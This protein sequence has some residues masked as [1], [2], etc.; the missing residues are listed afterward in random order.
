MEVINWGILGASGFARKQTAPAIHMARN[1]RLYG[2]ASRSGSADG[3]A[4]YQP[5][6]KVY[7]GYEAMLDDPDIHAVYIPLRIHLQVVWTIRALEAG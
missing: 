4:D 6:L 1:T 5:D 3:F 7:G 2:V